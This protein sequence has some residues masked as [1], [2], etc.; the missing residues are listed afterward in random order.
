MQAKF[1]CTLM[2]DLQLLTYSLYSSMLGADCIEVM[3]ATRQP[4]RNMGILATGGLSLVLAKLIQFIMKVYYAGDVSF[5]HSSNDRSNRK[6]ILPENMTFLS[7]PFNLDD[8]LRLLRNIKVTSLSIGSHSKFQIKVHQQSD[9]CTV[10][11]VFNFSSQLAKCSHQ[12]QQGKC[13]NI[14]IYTVHMRRSIVE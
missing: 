5:F 10:A 6:I 4:T 3:T 1:S 2:A 12:R 8:C 11:C 9:A 7:G 13:L 14:Y